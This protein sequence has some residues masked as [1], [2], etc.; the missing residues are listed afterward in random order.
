MFP[1]M[2]RL[3]CLL[4]DPGGTLRMLKAARGRKRQHLS[5][6]PQLHRHHSRRVRWNIASESHPDSSSKAHLYCAST[7]LSEQ[8]GAHAGAMS[9]LPSGLAAA[10]VPPQAPCLSDV[11]LPVSAQE[12]LPL[13][14]GASSSF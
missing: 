14:I 2:T 3:C 10:G 8:G 11:P 7:H 4:A 12:R 5:T 6:D 13:F 9:W 1:E